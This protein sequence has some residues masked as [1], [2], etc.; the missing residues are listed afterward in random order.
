MFNMSADETGWII[1]GI[2]AAIILGLVV[3][4]TAR[5]AARR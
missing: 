4:I 3:A 5:W 1:A 2:V